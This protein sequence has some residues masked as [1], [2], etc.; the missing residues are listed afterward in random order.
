MI[1]T[2]TNQLH[3]VSV[4]VRFDQS[5]IVL[6]SCS[7]FWTVS[8]FAYL[9]FCV[10]P[11]ISYTFFYKH[12]FFKVSHSTLTKLVISAIFYAYKMLSKIEHVV[13]ILQSTGHRTKNMKIKAK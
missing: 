8:Y 11:F 5:L 2:R 13:K 4:P 10:Y 12:S 6:V 7:K 1:H 3:Q 9:A